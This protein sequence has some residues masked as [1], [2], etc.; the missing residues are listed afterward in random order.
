MC[1][2]IENEHQFSSF[3]EIN[4]TRSSWNCRAKIIR[5][6]QTSNFNRNTLSFSIEMVLM[7][8]YGGRIHVTVKTTL[9]YKFKDELIEGRVYTFE[10]IGVSPN[11]G[12]YRTTHHSFKLNFKATTLI[13]RLFNQDIVR[14]PYNFVPIGQIVGGSYD[15]DFLVDVI[16]ILID[17]GRER[18]IN[19]QDGTPTKVNVIEIEQ[20]GSKIQCYLYGAYV[21]VLNAFLGAGHV[22]NVVVVMM[23]AKAVAFQGK[24]HIQNCLNSTYLS[25]NP[26]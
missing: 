11:V 9:I 14:S 13:Q 26:F 24:I 16:G 15:T 8:S 19:D 25:F 22:Q 1:M 17:V 3:V 6:W 23:F 18:E 21:D 20:D 12:A 7:D 4:S 5:L 10:K 2:T